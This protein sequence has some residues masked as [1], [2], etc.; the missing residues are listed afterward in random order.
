MGPS[1]IPPWRLIE[2][3]LETEAA[4]GPAPTAGATKVA[5]PAAARSGLL[6][7]AVLVTAAL[8]LAVAAFFLAVTSGSGD[9]IAIDGPS[10]SAPIPVAS[11]GARSDVGAPGEIVVE[12]IGAVARPGVFRLA[13]S[14]R[15][16]D[17]IEAAGGYGPR[18][19]T[20]R[21]EAEVRLA[22][23]LHDGDRVHVP[24]RD[25]PATGI[26]SASPRDGAGSALVDLNRATPAQLDALPGIGP[27][28]AEKIIAAREEAP[29]TTVDDLR[30]RGV[31][32]E[33][34]FERIREL[35][36]VS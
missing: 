1:A 28:T 32:G 12:V 22:A 7:T 26:A 30:S 15:V 24:S 35:V 9:Q 21:L 29:F 27:V 16:A 11:G 6:Q 31:L 17:L 2:A 18:V 4:P 33:K 36:A 8:A 20:A 5:D 3:P 23:P 13:S 14:A 19:D 34:T 25:E 10:G